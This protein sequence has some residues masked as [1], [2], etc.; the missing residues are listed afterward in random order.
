MKLKKNTLNIIL[1]IGFLLAVSIGTFKL[2]QNARLEGYIAERNKVCANLSV[3]LSDEEGIDDC[4]CYYEGFK[5]GNQQ[6]DEQT[7]PLCAC[8]C[9]INGTS[10]KV[11]LV[12]PRA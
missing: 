5:T 8:E 12:E 2:V 6:V 1:V 9:V 10:Y 3:A 7:M 4:Y 11:G